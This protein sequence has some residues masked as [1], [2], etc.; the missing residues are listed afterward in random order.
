[1]SEFGMQLDLFG[2]SGCDWCFEYFLPEQSWGEGLYVYCSEECLNESNGG[3][4][5]AED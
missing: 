1:M 5:D 3:D 2:W 4:E